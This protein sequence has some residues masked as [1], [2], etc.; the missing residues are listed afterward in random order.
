MRVKRKEQDPI[1]PTRHHFVYNRLNRRIAVAHGKFD[2]NRVAK[3][4]GKACAQGIR[5]VLGDQEQRRASP[6]IIPDLAVI[7][8][9]ARRADGQD[10]ALQNRLPFPRGHVHHPAVGQKFAQIPAHR[11]VIGAVWG[12]E[13]GEDDAGLAH[14]RLLGA[15]RARDNG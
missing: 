14:A 15:V 10:D 7:G 12:A 11:P 1:R 8:A 9:R 4:F 13:I 3:P 2:L 6:F 5:L